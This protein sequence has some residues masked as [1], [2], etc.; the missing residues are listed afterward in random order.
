MRN[1]RFPRNLG[2]EPLKLLFPKSS[3]CKLVRDAKSFGIGPE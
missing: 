1:E 3:V 2:I